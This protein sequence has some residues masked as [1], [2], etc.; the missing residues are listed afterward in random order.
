MDACS[1]CP[2]PS[3]CLKVGAC[4]DTLN[5]PR[6]ASGQFP[7]RMTPGQ[8]NELMAALREGK[9]IRRITNGGKFAPV[10]VSLTKLKKHCELYPEWGVEAMRLARVNA[11]RANALKS[12]K[13]YMRLCKYGH[14]LDS[15]RVYF[16]DGY[17]CR[18]CPACDKIRNARAGIIT[19]ETLAKV[20]VALRN[21]VTVNQ[22]VHGIPMG[23]GCRNSSLVVMNCAAFYRHRYENPEFNQLVRGEIEKRIRSSN[24]VLAVAAGTFKYEWDPGDHQLIR[25]MLPQYF[26]EKDVVINEVII[27]LLE[28]R[29][30]RTQIAHRIQWYV[31]DYNRARYA[32]FGNNKLFSLDERLFDDGRAT[33][34]DTVSRGLWD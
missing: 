25:S 22:V 18:R 23:G 7:Q 34:G 33:R 13:L 11:K 8:A 6:I 10:I 28:G 3:E 14:S 30:D 31:S 1:Q 9:T 26:Q 4:L 24:P 15:G 17:R 19:R 20:T 27:S 29:L 2:H 16:K 5:A 21:G 32:K 12:P